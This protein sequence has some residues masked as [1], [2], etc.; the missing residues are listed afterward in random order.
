M[1]AGSS[2]VP[3]P[4]HSPCLEK[5]LV[6]HQPSAKSC[7]MLAAHLDLDISPTGAK[8]SPLLPPPTLGL[9]PAVVTQPSDERQGTNDLPCLKPLRCPETAPSPLF[10]SALQCPIVL[11][12]VSYRR[13]QNPPLGPW[14]TLH[15]LGVLCQH[16]FD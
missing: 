12:C 6:Q 10:K 8:T 15:F 3:R 9:L 14:V 1:R 11:S 5:Y 7:C 16:R 2:S 13:F 4:L